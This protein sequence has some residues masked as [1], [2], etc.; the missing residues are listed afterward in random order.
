MS[1]STPSR[2]HLS[3]SLRGS[4]RAHR[5]NGNTEA[6]AVAKRDLAALTIES[7][8]ERILA[9]APPLT[10]EQADRIASILRGGK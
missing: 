4:I 10:D 5:L 3:R 8:V 9:D 7:H 2:E 6:A 1:V